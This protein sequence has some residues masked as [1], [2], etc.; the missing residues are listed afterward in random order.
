VQS[1]LRRL[2]R[3]TNQH[4]GKNDRRR[5]LASCALTAYGSQRMDA[6][7]MVLLQAVYLIEE[8]DQC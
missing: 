1:F 5:R 8:D 6:H 3:P 7:D 4:V 2:G